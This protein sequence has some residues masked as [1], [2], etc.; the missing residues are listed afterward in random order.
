MSVPRRE[1][2]ALKKLMKKHEI[3]PPSL[4]GGTFHVH[5]MHIGGSLILQE[6]ID[7][8]INVLV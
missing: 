5:K 6:Y 7:T 4:R 3:H 8:K 1:G 2:I